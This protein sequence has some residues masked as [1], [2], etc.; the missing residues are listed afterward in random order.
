MHIPFFSALGGME[1]VE[2][3]SDIGRVLLVEAFLFMKQS[4]TSE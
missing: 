2:S 3:S 4:E 1:W